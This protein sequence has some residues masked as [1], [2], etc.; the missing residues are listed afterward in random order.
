MIVKLN[1]RFL[2]GR[3]GVLPTSQT[4]RWEVRKIKY[5]RHEGDAIPVRL[6]VDTGMKPAL[7]LTV[8]AESGVMPPAR[9]IHSLAGTGLRGDVFADHGRIAELRIGNQSLKGVIASFGTG[10]EA[11]ALEELGVDGILGLGALYRFD[12]IFDYAHE[13]MFVRPNQYA[14]DE[15]ELNMAGMVI[16]E[17][18]SGDRIV[19]F[20]MEGTEAATRG[21]QKGDVLEEVNGRDVSALTYRELKGIFETAGTGVTV[22]TRRNGNVRVLELRLRR[23]I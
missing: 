1:L 8:N 13:R 22:R 6:A 7:A 19:A 4:T 12:L 9:V 17:T 14:S 20:V 23:I 10:D 3:G 5:R 15:F 11:P 2:H 16:D 21:V 18:V